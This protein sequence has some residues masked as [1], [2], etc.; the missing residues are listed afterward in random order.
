MVILARVSILDT[1]SHPTYSSAEPPRTIYDAPV[2]YLL[3][4]L[5]KNA[6]E[7]TDRLQEIFV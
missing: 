2:R 3:S 1:Y 5:P 4:T 7:M 6:V